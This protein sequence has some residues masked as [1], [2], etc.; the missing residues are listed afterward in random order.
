MS[1]NAI[2]CPNLMSA[3]HERIT[4]ATLRHHLAL[5]PASSFGGHS[6]SC[7]T[8]SPLQH[9][10]LFLEVPY[11][12]PIVSVVDHEQVSHAIKDL[13]NTLIFDNFDSISDKMVDIANLSSKENDG[14]TLKLCIQ[15]IFE[16]ASKRTLVVTM[17]RMPVAHSCRILHASQAMPA[18]GPLN[19][20]ALSTATDLA[21]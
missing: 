17:L 3:I 6:P 19:N 5:F 9:A 18:S 13:L 4:R 20:P 10:P 15:I 11:G 8:L 12:G 16:K 21:A 2:S 7:N 14:A 1:T